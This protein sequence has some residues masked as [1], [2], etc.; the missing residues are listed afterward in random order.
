MFLRVRQDARYTATMPMPMDTNR[1]VDP[2]LAAELALLAHEAEARWSGSFVVEPRAF[3]AYL[4]ARLELGA[5]DAERVRSNAAD[6]YLACGCTLGIP[7]AVRIFEATLG[8]EIAAALRHMHLQPSAL[9]EV[10]Q[11]TREKLLVGGAGRAPR[12]AEYTGRGTLRGWTRVVVTRTALNRLRDQ[13]REVPLEEALLDQRAT[14]TSNPELLCL[15]DRFG[16]SL[17]RALECAMRSL[18]ADERVLLRQR[19]VDGLTSEQLARVHRKHRITMVRRLNAI[20]RALRV[21]TE[22]LLA[23]EVGC[24][25]ATAVSIVNLALSQAHLSI[26]RYLTPDE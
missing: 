22:A 24:G 10:C 18:T 23:S 17:D 11:M 2:V 20:L 15:R 19:F 3:V 4:T 9:D 5:Q 25:H 16:V 14:D 7:E 6:L 21:R 12:I 26:R 1:G 13:K 8:T